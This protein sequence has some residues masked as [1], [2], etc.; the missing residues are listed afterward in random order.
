MKRIERNYVEKGIGAFVSFSGMCL[1]GAALIRFLIFTGHSQILDLPDPLLGIRIRSAV[2]ILALI[3]LAVGVFCLFG[4]SLGTRL[5]LLAWLTANWAVYRVGL[6]YLGCGVSCTAI[7]SLTDPLQL[8]RTWAGYV[9]MWLPA[10]LMVGAYVGIVWVWIIQRKN[11]AKFR[12]VVCP[13]CGGHIEFPATGVHWKI[14]C[15]H[16]GGGVR[17]KNLPQIG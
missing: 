2:G 12:K 9:V 3:E 8:S 10:A 14:A 5:T 6:F 17:L 15:P 7:G 11:Q 1:L 4:K 13:G 16:C